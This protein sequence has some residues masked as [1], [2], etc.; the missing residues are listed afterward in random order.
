MF[1]SLLLSQGPGVLSIYRSSVTNFF[2]P[3][4]SGC[5]AEI[6]HC[7]GVRE[8]MYSGATSA[9]K[10]SCVFRPVSSRLWPPFP[11]SSQW[12]LLPL[13]SALLSFFFFPFYFILFYFIVVVF[14]IQWHESAMDLH[15]F[16]IPIPPPASLPIPSLWVFPVHQSRAPV[17]CIQP[18]LG[19]CFTLD[20]IQVSMLFSQIIPSS[21]SPIESKSLVCTS[22]SLSLSCI[23]KF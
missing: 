3:I 20:N 16:P 23:Y 1:V 18:G 22:V 15:V 5:S 7:F 8:H 14:A 19:I 21:P 11:S 2:P 10:K 6:G 17:S 4:L 13:H 12:C 9:V